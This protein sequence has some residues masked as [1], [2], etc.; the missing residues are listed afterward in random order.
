MSVLDT[1]FGTQR[2]RVLSRLLLHPDERLHVRELARLTGTH[3]GSLHREL[4]RLADAGLL[5]RARQGNQVLYQ[6]NRSCPVFEELA[7]LFRKTAGV[8]DILRM[9]LQPLA[10][11]IAFAFVFGSVARGEESANSDVDVLLIG[12]NLDFAQVVQ[13]L[14]PSQ[15]ALGREVNPVVYAPLEFKRKLSEGDSFLGDVMARPRLFIQ[16]V[17]DD[18]GKFAGSA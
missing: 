9:A 1:L 6:A 17:E 7:G 13:A 15:E 2:Q 12:E 18:F 4:A 10:E 16:G 14:Y 11:Q 5:L 3:A 8:V